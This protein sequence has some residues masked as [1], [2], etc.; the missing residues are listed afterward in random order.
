MAVV[1][2]TR[3]RPELLAGLLDV[4][5][6]A[7]DDRC[8]VVVV[9]SASRTPATAAVCARLGVRALRLEKPGTS[10]AR[11][12]GIAGTTADLV[13]FTDDDCLPQP[14]WAGALRAAFADPAVGLV[15]GRVLTDVPTSAPLS[16]TTE[17]QS[18]ALSVDDVVG[19]GANA[20]VR[21]RALEQVGGFDESLGPGTPLRAAEDQDLFR[22]VLAAGWSGRFTADAVVLHRQWRSRRAA[23]AT[24]WAYGVGAGAA[25]RRAGSAWRGPVV[26]DALRPAVRDLRAGYLTGTAAGLLRAAGALVGTVRGGT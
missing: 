10:R 3:D 24:S 9:D 16:V 23:L 18:R 1:V 14:G 19:H 17:R 12:A 26:D 22:R 11:N 15:T 25:A 7:L 21:R 6:A 8:E 20:A 13:A 5:P 2:A 4:L